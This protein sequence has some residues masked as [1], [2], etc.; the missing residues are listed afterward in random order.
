MPAGIR[1]GT[2][3][4]GSHKSSSSGVATSA[5]P[6]PVVPFTRDAASTIRAAGTRDMGSTPVGK[7]NST[8]GSD[9]EGYLGIRD[10]FLLCKN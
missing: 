1:T 6:N 4:R 10:D 3:T 2:I 5:N 9:I 7:G 8:P